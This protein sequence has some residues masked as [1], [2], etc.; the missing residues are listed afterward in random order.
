MK[1][2]ERLGLLRTPHETWA[3]NYFA[4]GGTIQSVKAVSPISRIDRFLV[5]RIGQRKLGQ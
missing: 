5:R 1:L 3:A 2:L 4:S